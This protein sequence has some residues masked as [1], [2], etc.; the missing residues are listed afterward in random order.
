MAVTESIK[1]SKLWSHNLFIICL[2]KMVV[3]IAITVKIM[4]ITGIILTIKRNVSNTTDN[5]NLLKDHVI[6]I[7]T[8]GNA[9]KTEN[10]NARK[11]GNRKWEIIDWKKKKREM[12]K[13]KRNYDRIKENKRKWGN[14]RK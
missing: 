2:K 4:K 3:G 7:I 9:K 14:T 6:L 8:M 12:G 5:V 10:G 1:T 11:T 13:T